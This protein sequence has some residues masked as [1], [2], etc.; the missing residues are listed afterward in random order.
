MAP[1][2]RFRTLF[3]DGDQ[4]GNIPLPHFSEDGDLRCLKGPRALHGGPEK[5]GI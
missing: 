3:T 5:D 4:F 2:A 1:V